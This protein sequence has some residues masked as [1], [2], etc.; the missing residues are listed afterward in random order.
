MSRTGALAGSVLGAWRINND[1][2]RFLVSHIPESIWT[3]AVPG[4]PD[5]LT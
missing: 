2:T 5:V 4:I 3:A 1:V